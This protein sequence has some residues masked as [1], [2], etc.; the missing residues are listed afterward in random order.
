MGL[1][2]AFLI[3]GVFM[4]IAVIVLARRYR[5]IKTTDNRVP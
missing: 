2:I 5:M 1:G 3:I 4:T